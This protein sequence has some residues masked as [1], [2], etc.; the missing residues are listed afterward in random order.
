MQL[1]HA[2]IADAFRKV[3]EQPHE[4][5]ENESQAIR[6]MEE[7]LEKDVW[8]FSKSGYNFTIMELYRKIK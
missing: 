5:F 6:H 4:G 8:I 3:E 7:S 1:R 2:G